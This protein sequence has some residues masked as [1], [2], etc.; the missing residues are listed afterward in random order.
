MK[1]KITANNGAFID[2]K[3]IV[4]G[5]DLSDFVS[6]LSLFTYDGRVNLVLKLLPDEV[7]IDTPVDNVIKESDNDTTKGPI[8]S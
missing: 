5:K 8:H 2:G 1:V 6:D 7:E 4:D 3:V